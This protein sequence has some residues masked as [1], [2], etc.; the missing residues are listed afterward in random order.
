MKGI[1]LDRL[2]KK[3]PTPRPYKRQ[4][5]RDKHDFNDKYIAVAFKRFKATHRS[6]LIP[7][8]RGVI[9]KRD[10]KSTRLNSS[11]VRTSRMPSSA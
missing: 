2:W 10:R 5:Q 1:Y 4:N 3:Y 11:H 9:S 6:Y 8:K 7:K